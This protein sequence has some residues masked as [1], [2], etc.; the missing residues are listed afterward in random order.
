[1]GVNIQV[2]SAIPF[3]QFWGWL[4]QHANCLLR[5]GSVDA[6]LYDHESLH[7]QLEE[8]GDGNPNVLQVLGKVVVAELVIET[9]E[10]LFVQAIPDK[11]SEQPGQFVF[12]VVGGPREEPYP[13]YHFLLTHG[14]EGE[15]RSSHPLSLK[16]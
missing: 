8:D 16:H 6:F 12:E 15:E 13:L 11:E 1:M 10:I 4:K 2:G 7:W 9:N 14:F 3:Q 5:A